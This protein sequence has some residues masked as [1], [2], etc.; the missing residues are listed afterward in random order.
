MAPHWLKTHGREGGGQV[1][2]EAMAVSG[3]CHPA[4]GGVGRSGSSRNGCVLCAKTIRAWMAGCPFVA[5]L[6][7]EVQ[8]AGPGGLATHRDS[9][10]CA[11]AAGP[12]PRSRTVRPRTW[13]PEP[14]CQSA[15]VSPCVGRPGPAGSAARSSACASMSRSG[16]A[17]GRMTLPAYVGVRYDNGNAAAYKCI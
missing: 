7:D 4:G 5:D 6:T 16:G 14:G 11:R 12:R 15:S 9:G 10:A 1:A 2:V 13:P 8:F 3:F 17:V